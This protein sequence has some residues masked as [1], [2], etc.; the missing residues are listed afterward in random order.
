M[1]SAH[2]KIELQSTD[3]LHYLIANVT[4]LARAKIDQ[5][6][7][8]ENDDGNKDNDDKR[9]AL[10]RRRRRVIEEIVNAVWGY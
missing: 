3:D 1:E 4:R 2:R 5:Q 7:P 9:N 10:R 6:I 8:G